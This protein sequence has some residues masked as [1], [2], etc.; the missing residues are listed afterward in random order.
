MS[1]Q[2]IDNNDFVVIR[3]AFHFYH[4]IFIILYML[5]I[6][7]TFTYE[8]PLGMKL[9][10]VLGL[11]ILSILPIYY[12]TV[13]KLVIYKTGIEYIDVG[14]RIF[15]TWRNIKS[16]YT[17][18]YPPIRLR[19]YWR[20]SYDEIILS[21]PHII[22]NRIILFLLKFTRKNNKIN[23]SQFDQGWRFTEWGKYI[24]IKSK[25]KYWRKNVHDNK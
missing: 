3:P 8:I 1:D 18:D 19:Y 10:F 24:C 20:P 23:I 22:S 21:N 7:S 17:H 9:L 6:I 5:M 4:L 11:L 12:Y 25:I 13:K 16:I 14:Y 15:A 2:V